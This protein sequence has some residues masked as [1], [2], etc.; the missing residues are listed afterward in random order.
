MNFKDAYKLYNDEIKGDPNVLDAILN[1]KQKKTPVFFMR[2]A[3]ACA[4]AAMIVVVSVVGFNRFG[5]ISSE[6]TK[7]NKTYIAARDISDNN[8]IA[9][10]SDNKEITVAQNNTES[11]NSGVQ[12]TETKDAVSYAEKRSG[13]TPS[14]NNKSQ[15]FDKTN[16][17]SV[18]SNNQQINSIESNMLEDSVSSTNNEP[19]AAPDPGM[20]MT[21]RMQPE[22]AVYSPDEVSYEEY[23]SY[24]GVDVL[25]KAELPSDMEFDPE[26]T[27]N[28][29]KNDETDEV[30]SGSVT[31][32]AQSNVDRQRTLSMSVSKNESSPVHKEYFYNETNGEVIGAK[33]VTEKVAVVVESQKVTQ[34]EIDTLIDS[35]QTN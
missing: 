32:W 34:T 8:E 2:P 13:S 27:V 4:M 29:Q 28:A 6:Q 1:G 10:N 21:T 14:V 26:C 18:K 20:P 35:L 16:T 31:V 15:N 12:K 17:N 25:Q 23:S 7:P 19:V 30:A 5:N 3:F 24:L 9:K 11:K 22:E 33:S